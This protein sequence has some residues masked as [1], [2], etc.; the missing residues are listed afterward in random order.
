MGIHATFITYIKCI[1]HPL[2]NAIIYVHE[3]HTL[4]HI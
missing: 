3:V 2:F 1:L 4:P